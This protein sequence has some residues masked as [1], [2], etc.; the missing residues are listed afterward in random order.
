MTLDNDSVHA[1]GGMS[2]NS[3]EKISGWDRT[4]VFSPAHVQLCLKVQSLEKSR[5]Y[6]CRKMDWGQR[7]MPVFI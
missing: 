6:R 7:C 4:S 5:C 2:F 1:G 3:R